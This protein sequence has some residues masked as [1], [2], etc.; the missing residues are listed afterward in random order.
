MITSKEIAHFPLQT[1]DVH[2]TT[3]P[4][5]KKNVISANDFYHS[6]TTRPTYFE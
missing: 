1:V 2:M 5:N 4:K 6:P 3:V